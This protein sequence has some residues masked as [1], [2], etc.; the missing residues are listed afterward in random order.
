MERQRWVLGVLLVCL[1]LLVSPAHAS[2]GEGH[3]FTPPHTFL[4]IGGMVVLAKIGGRLAELINQPKVLGEIVTGIVLVALLDK[5][6]GPEI[7][8]GLRNSPEVLF[9]ATFG[10]M[11]LLF[12]SGLG[13]DIGHMFRVGGHALLVA[14]IGV[15][16]PGAAGFLFAW[17][18]M[19][20]SLATSLFIGSTLTATSVGI[21]AGTFSDLGIQ[22]SDER[23]IV[24]GAAVIDDVLGLI[25]LATIPILI[26]SM[27]DGASSAHLGWAIGIPTIAALATLVCC[28]FFGMWVAP[29]LSRIS[30]FRA[31]WEMMLG[32]SVFFLVLLACLGAYAGGLALIVGAFVAGLVFKE[33]HFHHF[34]PDGSA[35]R[36]LKH[37]IHPLEAFFVPIFFIRT[38]MEVNLG[39][40]LKG[41]FLLTLIVV[42]IIAI[43]GKLWSGCLLPRSL[44]RSIVGA[45][46]IPRGEVGMIFAQVAKA[47]GA[48]DD[49]LYLL[50][51]LV[52]ALTTVVTPP[53]LGWLIRRQRCATDE[54][55]TPLSTMT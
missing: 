52:I 54:E 12:S 23:R 2:G 33:A 49:T 11:L 41:E 17:L 36:T 10:A 7:S 3:G 44:N 28:V 43:L 5:V 40:E 48:I 55:T 39:I 1:S 22:D 16:L 45:G 13:E 21:T 51:I 38:G 30:A 15:V 27:G 6:L 46:M 20:W 29:R 34:L 19:G 35:Y 42:F 32:V 37:T 26:E 24:L 18:W 8:A 47:Q 50:C 4:F 14:V 25:L 53:W 9:C 31:D